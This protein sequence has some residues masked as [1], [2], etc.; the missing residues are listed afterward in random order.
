MRCV[1]SVRYNL[2][3]NGTLLDSFASSRGLWK[4]DAL[5]PFLFLFVADGLDAILKQDIMEHRISPIRLCAQA[6]GISH[7]LFTDDTLVFFRANEVEANQVKL[8]L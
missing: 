6:P 4:G 5:S 2:K 7:L 1:T 8:A 3:V